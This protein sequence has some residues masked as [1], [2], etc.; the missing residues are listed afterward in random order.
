M[1]SSFAVVLFALALVAFSLACSDTTPERTATRST[2]GGSTK[3]AGQDGEKV[4]T[5]DASPPPIRCTD[6][7]LSAN[8]KTDGG[9]LEITFLAGA[10]PKQ[11]ENRCATVKVGA[12]VTFSGSFTQHP[13]QAAGG[14]SPSPIPYTAEDQPDGR[15]VVTMSR[16]GTFGFECEFHPKQMFGAIRV[17]P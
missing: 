7:E 5:V 9:A 10:N 1:K 6:A 3:D 8:D 13:L 2:D 4:V 11:Y 17:L 14:D 15:L 16:A 12:T